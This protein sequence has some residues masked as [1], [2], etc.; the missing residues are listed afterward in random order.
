MATAIVGVVGTL[1]GVGLGHILG[2]QREHARW[3]NDQK[4]LEYKE[5]LD[6]LYET[7]AV[8]TKNRPNLSQVTSGPIDDVVQKL[9]RLFEDR[10][11][12]ARR[13]T[14]S[15][16][17]EDWIAMKKVIY[18]YR[19]L[20]SQT[21]KEFWYTHNNLHEREDKLRTKILE[22]ADRDIVTFKYWDLAMIFRRRTDLCAR[23]R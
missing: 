13:L 11:F 9:S 10:L 16:A 17:K 5:L 12:V 22:L 2:A 3:V 20:Q 23:K 19:E 8:V 15:G 1:A 4:R 6:Q 21:P 18:Y 7:I 14:E